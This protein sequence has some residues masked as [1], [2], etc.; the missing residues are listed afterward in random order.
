MKKIY[1]NA[2][3]ILVLSLTG[4]GCGSLPVQEP[5]TQTPEKNYI[6]QT[7][8]FNGFSFTYPLS[9]SATTGE[10]IEA[11]NTTILKSGYTVTDN[12]SGMPGNEREFPFEI[13]ITY[14][15]STKAMNLSD[16]LKKANPI[17][18]EQYDAYKAGKGTG[19]MKALSVGG[20]EAY[21]F[22]AGAEG[23]NVRHVFVI[24]N[25]KEW[26]HIQLS[27]IGEILSKSIK[28]K[29]ISEAE[30]LKIFNDLLAS[31]TFTK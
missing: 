28:P 14:V 20:K 1:L 8:S 17:W 9:F 23:V 24:K 22:Q 25:D 26:M 3:L 11:Q 21:E 18:K 27:F 30:Q 19:D 12:P 6:T 5:T 31:F 13:R 4:A 16:S 7:D 29:T 10:G 2:I 15:S